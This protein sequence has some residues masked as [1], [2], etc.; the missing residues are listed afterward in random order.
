MMMR[1]WTVALLLV[2]QW[3]AA[4]SFERANSIYDAGGF[5]AAKQ[6][7]DQMAR[8]GN[9]DAQFNLAAMYYRGEGGPRDLQ[10]AY[11]WARVAS[12]HGQQNAAALVA[13]LE[14]QLQAE[15]ASARQQ[16]QRVR[17]QAGPERMPTLYPVNTGRASS[18]KHGAPLFTAQPTFPASMARAGK[19]GWVDLMFVVGKDGSV[20]Y[21]SI[22]Y[23]MSQAFGRAA[24]AAALQSRWEPATLSGRP[25]TSFGVPYRYIFAMHG[26]EL[27]ADEL[28]AYLDELKAKA[29][30][31]GS[32]DR[33][34][35][36]YSLDGIASFIHSLEGSK[37]L[38][39]EN[40]MP[41]YSEAA[42]YGSEFAM[43]RL[44]LNTLYGSQCDVDP[45]KAQHWLE[46][47]AQ[48]NL[49]DA[50][51]AL[52]HQLVSGSLLER[53]VDAGL[54]LLA[55]AAE[56]GYDHARV[57]Y[58]WLQATAEAS[59]P[60]LSRAGVFLAKIPRDYIDQRSYLEAKAA[61]ALANND[62][63]AARKALKS[64]RKVNR[65]WGASDQR[66][67]A[68]QRALV[69]QKAYREAI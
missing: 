44:G 35:Y 61:L 27:R 14:T 43:F 50:K 41:W 2:S 45:H 60:D 40:P 54:A 4:V 66:E 29:T 55:D 15:L 65:K 26:S 19:S 11:A 22:T 7:Y 52:G 17:E 31:G 1:I 36:A 68:L 39:L 34:S 13:K 58:A 51:F 20:R 47:A 69:E 56:S 42:K 64:L 38:V 3:A 23:Q 25:V 16:Y 28:K 48:N 62:W 46:I 5:D 32:L 24:L 18:Y 33:L 10:A 63:N 67:V 30:T 8:L 49:L 57:H 6:A 21:P 53:D 9:A 59:R 12:D 37:G